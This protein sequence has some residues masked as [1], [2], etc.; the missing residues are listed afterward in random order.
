MI[1]VRKLMMR[2]ATASVLSLVTLSATMAAPVQGFDDLYNAAFAACT[3]ADGRA[4]VPAACEAAINA[5]A[6][7]LIE[8]GV[9]PAL[10]LGSF[11]A[12]RADVAAAGGGAAIAD[13]FEQL[14]PESGSLTPA[15]P[16]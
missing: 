2:F 7:A 16:S 11:T 1:L 12:L 8:A 6:A 3:P 14:L 13:L 5:Y 4:A 10:A 15:S 9:D